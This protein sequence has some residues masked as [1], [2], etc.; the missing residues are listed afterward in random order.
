[1]PS[2]TRP[3]LNPHRVDRS[4]RRCNLSIF[5][6]PLPFDNSLIRGRVE[7]GRVIENEIEKW[8]T[9]LDASGV[10]QDLVEER[11]IMNGHLVFDCV[12]DESH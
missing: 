9:F 6:L 11:E 12:P 10:V 2:S 7:I 4:T 8:S 3:S 1:M 5:A